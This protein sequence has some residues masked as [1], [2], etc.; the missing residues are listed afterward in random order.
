M[1]ESPDTASEM[2]CPMVLQA[3]VE[4]V[5]VLLLL[6]LTP[7]TYH[8]V[9]ANAVEPRARNTATT[10]KQVSSLSLMIVSL[11]GAIV[12][13]CKLCVLVSAGV[14]TCKSTSVWRSSYLLRR[15]ATVRYHSAAR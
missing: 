14:A 4:D 11:Q 13:R 5:Q 10:R 1:T 3:V 9:V 15:I 2:A 8:V 7:L 6:P 12:A